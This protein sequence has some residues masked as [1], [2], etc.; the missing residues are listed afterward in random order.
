MMGKSLGVKT[1]KSGM[2]QITT[3]SNVE[4]LEGKNII[5]RKEERDSDIYID[6]LQ[7]IWSR[8]Q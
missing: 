8:N 2:E 1:S 6:I 7:V 5:F 3:S 4:D